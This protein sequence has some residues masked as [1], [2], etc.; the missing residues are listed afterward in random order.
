MAEQLNAD[1]EMRVTLV[2][3][4]M[5]ERHYIK[6]LNASGAR[7]GCEFCEAAALTKGRGGV[8]WTY[9]NCV[10]GQPRTRERMIY[11]AR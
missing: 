9:P 4:D 1:P 6:G 7:L 2:L 10:P 8:R 11:F 3:C 5:V